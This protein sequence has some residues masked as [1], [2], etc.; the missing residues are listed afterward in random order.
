METSAIDHQFILRTLKANQERLRVEFGIERIGLYGSYARNEQTPQSD[1]DL[2]YEMAKGRNL[3]LLERDRLQ[4]ILRRKLGRKLDL[5]N[6]QIMNPF[7]AYTMRKDV[8]Y[9]Q[10]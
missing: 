1:I 4:R 2:V 5:V 8:I 10:C 6:N 9:V 7:I 3:G